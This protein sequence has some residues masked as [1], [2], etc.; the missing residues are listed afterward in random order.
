MGLGNK[1]AEALAEYLAGP[2]IKLLFGRLAWIEMAIS[3][4]IWKA[5]ISKFFRPKFACPNIYPVT[6]GGSETNALNAALGLNQFFL[7]SV[8]LPIIIIAVLLIGVVY[9]LNH[10]G[11]FVRKVR[12]MIPK[13]MGATILAF[14][15]PLWMDMVLDLSRGLLG[16]ITDALNWSVFGPDSILDK[17]MVDWGGFWGAGGGT[18]GASLAEAGSAIL[19]FIIGFVILT[20][21]FIVLLALSVR[22]AVVY[23]G[24]AT[25]PIASILLGIPKLDQVGKKFWKIWIESCFFIFF[26]AIPVFLL[27]YVNDAWLMLGLLVLIIGAPFLVSAG[28]VLALRSAGFPSAGQAASGAFQMGTAVGMLTAGMKGGAGIASG[29][30]MAARGG[31]KAV[32]K[33]GKMA[34]GG[35]GGSLLG[36]LAGFA[37][38]KGSS[39][40]GLAGDTGGKG[41][42]TGSSIAQAFSGKRQSVFGSGGNTGSSGVSGQTGSGSST[43]TG[44]SGGNG[45]TRGPIGTNLDHSGTTTSSGSSPVGVPSAQKSSSSSGAGDVTSTSSA[46]EGTGSSGT[47]KSGKKEKVGMKDRIKGT[48]T[49]ATEDVGHGLKA[50]GAGLAHGL[51]G[52][53]VGGSTLDKHFQTPQV[54]KEKL[55]TQEGTNTSETKPDLKNGGSAGKGSSSTKSSSSVGQKIKSSL[56]LNGS[57]QSKEHRNLSRRIAKKHY[58]L[59]KNTKGGVKDTGFKTDSRGRVKV[60]SDIDKAKNLE[61]QIDSKIPDNQ[62]LESPDDN[63]D[64]WYKVDNSEGGK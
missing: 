52:G 50:V 30:L 46:S 26:M 32:G 12:N 29:G 47:S 33:G 14:T 34:M 21:V 37:A 60:P 23:F 56:G 58:T 35:G 59:N 27:P 31:A 9:V 43:D 51:T 53:R 44:S 39:G 7:S 1:I 63:L 54:D 19:A 16:V 42:G 3:E 49:S 55:Q 2:A 45:P 40:G 61:K 6:D 4:Q 11:P 62:S 22:L 28:G 20:L 64:N 41:S 25:M 24:I 10:F 17:V 8:V 18:Y 38:G 15:T 5:N 48:H 13:L 57:N 36:S